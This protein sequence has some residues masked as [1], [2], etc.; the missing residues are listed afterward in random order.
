MNTVPLR[1]GQ[2][3]RYRLGNDGRAHLVEDE[4]APAA[5]VVPPPDALAVLAGILN[6]VTNADATKKRIAEFADAA[7]NARAAIADA[8]REQEKAA[9]DRA[10][11]DAYVAET[12]TKQA[13]ALA[14][15][16]AAHERALAERE[17]VVSQKEARASEPEGRAA[18]AADAAETLRRTLKAKLDQIAK[19]TAAD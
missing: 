12:Q 14:S 16:R 8:K 5:E 3:A 2:P 19:V 11:A 18:K 7:N 15:E 17:K 1:P 6:L 9:A 10:A 4:P 13:E